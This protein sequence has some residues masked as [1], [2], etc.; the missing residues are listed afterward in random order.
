M[1]KRVVAIVALACLLTHSL[2]A[3]DKKLKP[4]T[5]WSK[6]EV[7]KIL[8]DSAWGQTQTVTDTSEMYYSPTVTPANGGPVRTSARD[9]QG[10]TNQ[11]TNVKYRIRWL[12]AR[13]IR[14]ALMRLVM[15]N[16]KESPDA[17]LAE[18]MKTYAE[19]RAEDEIVIAVTFEAN[20]QRF[21]G[22]AMQA[23]NSA[24]TASLKNDTYLERND[25]QRIF[26]K[27][28]APPTNDGFGARFIFPRMTG[29]KAF[30]TDD[31]G[32]VRF[33]SKLGRGIEFNMKFNVAQMKYN[34][35]LEY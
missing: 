9:T 21:G 20:D 28:Y 24:T 26:L 27:N 25:G 1:S 15:L 4:W 2:T 19:G 22:P 31:T 23:F 17:S 6:K 33:F 16:M 7:E 35:A 12:S 5:E 13:P 34:D 18:R 14:Q 29:E 10:A 11:P 32:Q 3:Q 30:I 8:N